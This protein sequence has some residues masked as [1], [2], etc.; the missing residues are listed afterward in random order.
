MTQKEQAIIEQAENAWTGITE[1]DLAQQRRGPGGNGEHYAPS[2]KVFRIVEDIATCGAEHDYQDVL[3]FGVQGVLAMYGLSLYLTKDEEQL[4]RESLL[5][6]GEQRQT[7]EVVRLATSC[8]DEPLRGLRDRSWMKEKD[9]EQE[10][11]LDRA[12]WRKRS[13]DPRK[14]LVTH[15]AEPGDAG[16]PLLPGWMASAERVPANAAAAT[17]VQP[18]ATPAAAKVPAE[19]RLVTV[20]CSS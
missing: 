8:V 7:S 10:H 13:A 9:L 11:K 15:I 3:E 18:A 20:E 1:D 4:M 16:K 5:E 19:P 14:L 6:M 17:D 2:F 12:A